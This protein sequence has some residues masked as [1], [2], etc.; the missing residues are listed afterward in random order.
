MDYT[1]APVCQE[2]LVRIRRQLHMYPER[3]WD[4]PLT[5]ALVREELDKAGVPYEFGKYGENT[6]V[7]T[8]NPEKAGFTI[9]IAI[10]QKV[11]N[12]LAPSIRALSSISSELLDSMNCFIR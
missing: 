9:G 8:I 10:D 12:S 6:I 1:I 3:G 5:T 7:A 2:E 11:L 4:L